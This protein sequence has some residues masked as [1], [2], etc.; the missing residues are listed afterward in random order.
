MK[1]TIIGHSTVLLETQEMRI[2]TDPYFGLK[3]NLAYARIAPPSRTREDLR[4]VH[5]V[6]VSHNHWDHTDPRFFRSLAP[7]VPVLAPKG[8]APLT[9]LKGAKNVIGL[10]KWEQKQFAGANI[11][12]VPASHI[13]I[14]R[15]YVIQADGKTIYFAGDTYYRPFM[16]DIGARFQLDLALLPV[17]TYRIPMTMGEESAVRAVRALSP[18]T[19]I[20]IHLGITPRNPLLR[21]KDTPEGFRQRVQSAGLPVNLP[22]A[23][24]GCRFLAAG[25]PKASRGGCA[26]DDA[27]AGSE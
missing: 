7:D 24:A 27:W 11:T 15:G 14:T 19:V 10:K 21:T 18:R 4:D 6:L 26:D 8:S 9:R 13:A 25:G 17:T 22:W 5:L 23:P 1:I 2:L 20:P 16:Q 3:G 12:A